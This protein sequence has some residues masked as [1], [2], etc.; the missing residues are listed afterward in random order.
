M[1]AIFSNK[2]PPIPLK[3][4]FHARRV[5]PFPVLRNVRFRG[6]MFDQIKGT[7]CNSCGK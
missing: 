2:P 1:F 4:V 3:K 6:N 7:S 5:P